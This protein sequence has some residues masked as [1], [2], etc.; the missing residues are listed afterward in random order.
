MAF[1]VEREVAEANDWYQVHNVVDGYK[2]MKKI[3]NDNIEMD[4]THEVYYEQNKDSGKFRAEVISLR[5]LA[6]NVTLAFDIAMWMR[7]SPTETDEGLF[8]LVEL[9]PVAKL[10]VEMPGDQ[11]RFTHQLYRRIWYS[12]IFGE[13]FD[14]WAEYAVEEL[15]RYVNA[16]RTFYGLEPT[17]ARTERHHYEP[18][19]SGGTT[20]I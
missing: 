1:T 3:L 19:V 12:L 15:N 14:Y 11:H 20:G 5:E 10:V 2:K 6:D 16:M 9:N 7:S 13:Q 4:E 8:G 18:L 17:M